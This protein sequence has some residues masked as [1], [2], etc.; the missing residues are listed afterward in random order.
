[1]LIVGTLQKRVLVKFLHGMGD[2]ATSKIEYG[3]I[4]R[5]FCTLSDNTRFGT[6]VDYWPVIAK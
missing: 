1:V 6:S 4:I 2:G 3:G 5:R